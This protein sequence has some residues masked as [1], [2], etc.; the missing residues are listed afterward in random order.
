MTDTDRIAPDTEPADLTT[1][2]NE[3]RP[4]R[5]EIARLRP[6]V[7]MAD[8]EQR[9]AEPA[10]DTNAELRHSLVEARQYGQRNLERLC[11]VAADRDRAEAAL[12]RVNDLAEHYETNCLGSTARTIREAVTGRPQN[13]LPTAPSCSG[14]RAAI[15]RMLNCAA[16][17]EA[18]PGSSDNAETARII[19]NAV[20]AQPAKPNTE[21]TLMSDRPLIHQMR[22]RLAE[23]ARQLELTLTDWQ[24]DELA[25]AATACAM[26]ND[27]RC[28]PEPGAGETPDA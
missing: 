15:G 21:E 23:E 1:A 26:S 18:S 5:A 11:A 25:Y 8:N 10:E 6:F 16:T 22:D 7:D 13:A 3:L 27:P 4:A 12:K 2:L 28:Q 17:F 19:R 9:E 24:L 20:G 14:L